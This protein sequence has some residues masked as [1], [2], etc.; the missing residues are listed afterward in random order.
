MV[1]KGVLQLPTE[2]GELIPITDHR[3]P[4]TD[5]RISAEIR[6]DLSYNHFCNPTTLVLKGSLELFFSHL[7]N[8]YPIFALVKL[9][10]L[11]GIS[12]AVSE[13]DI[14]L[15]PPFLWN[16]TA[17]SRSIFSLAKVSEVVGLTRLEKHFRITLPKVNEY[18]DQWELWRTL[19]NAPEFESSWCT[20]V[21]F[22]GKSWFDW[23]KPEAEDLK[24]Y[25]YHRVWAATEY[26]RNQYVWDVVYSMFKQEKLVKVNPAIADT[27]RQLSL[28]A[29]GVQPG[30]VVAQDNEPAPIRE[31]QKAL[32][33]IYKIDYLPIFMYTGLFNFESAESIAYYSLEYPVNLTVSPSNKKG[34]TKIAD[35]LE[36]KY[37]LIKFKFLKKRQ[38]QYRGFAFL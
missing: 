35:L 7:A 15:H 19:A 9:G 21:L 6:E 25:L 8:T 4:I 24:L 12:P 33:D 14:N 10:Q 23:S 30:F 17:G 2:S 38:A 31:F 16:M 36:I 13:N 32:I 34:A 11:I 1:K 18:K 20:E 26:W 37:L 29:V 5:E 22:F 27:V 3:S 28:V